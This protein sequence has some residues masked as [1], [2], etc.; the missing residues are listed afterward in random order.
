MSVQK[1]TYDDFLAC[2]PVLELPVTVTTDSRVEFAKANKPFPQ[3]IIEDFLVPIEQEGIDEFTEFEPCF[4]FAE[5]EEFDAVVYWRGKIYSYEYILAIFDRKQ[6]LISRKSIAGS[7]FEKERLF[8]SAANIS[9]DFIIS[10]VAGQQE[11]GDKN[12]KAEM[13]QS[14]TFEILTT[15]DIIFSLQDSDYL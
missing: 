6:Q 4:R 8:Q 2:F 11:E 12:Y 14:M 9:E 1:P 7:R 5:D 10:I 15:G 13:S 3:Q